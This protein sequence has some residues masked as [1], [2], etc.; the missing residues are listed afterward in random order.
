VSHLQPALTHWRLP[1][2]AAVSG[3]VD[4]GL[5]NTTCE[6]R[7][8]DT[9]VGYLQRLN[10]SIF[11]PAVHEDIAQITSAVA[12]AGLCT[13]KIVPCADGS[14]WHEDDEGGV[15]RC[16][17]PV[18]SRTMVAFETLQHAQS[19]GRLVGRWH[20][21]LAD[22]EVPF[23]SVR[24]GAHDT[25]AHMAGLQE[26]L[27]AHRGHRLFADVAPLAEQILAGWSATP[28]V[29]ELPQR[30]IHGDLKVSN[31][32][33]SGDDAVAII[34]LDTCAYGTIDVELGDALRSWCNRASEDDAPH[35]DV[36]VLEAALRGYADGAGAGGLSGAEWQ[37]VVPGLER[38][39]WELSARFCKDALEERYFGWDTRFGTRGAHNLAR[40][41]GQAGLAAQVASARGEADARV[42]QIRDEIAA[43]S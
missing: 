22:F 34:D 25:E 29:G 38:I 37:S 26:A 19:A 39:C 9:V 10:T 17:T 36:D 4:T 7:V 35:F 27:R 40:A 12:S 20:S 32:R 6:L 21:A 18:G 31:L 14:L 13:P 43:D 8:G 24:A 3:Q 5:I 33:F 15:W 16:L 1:E 28:R 41:R 23:Q 2:G 11:V 30:V 42:R